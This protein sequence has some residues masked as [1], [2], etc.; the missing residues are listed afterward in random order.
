MHFKT[1][2]SAFQGFISLTALCLCFQVTS[3]MCTLA[4]LSILR[5]FLCLERHV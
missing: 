1:L 4:E 3:V 2:L 5:K